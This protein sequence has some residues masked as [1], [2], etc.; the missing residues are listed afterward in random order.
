G[1]KI[2][3]LV[4]E[5]RFLSRAQAEFSFERNRTGRGSGKREFPR[6][7]S[8]ETARFQ[9]VPNFVRDDVRFLSRA[10]GLVYELISLLAD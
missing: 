2:A 6:G 9:G 5:V 7:G 4:I 10:Q 8:I 1:R 3:D